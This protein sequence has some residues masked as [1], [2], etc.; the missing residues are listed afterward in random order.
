MSYLFEQP[1]LVDA[2][3]TESLLGVRAQDLDVMLADMLGVVRPATLVERSD[4][5]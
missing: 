2:S 1:L 5:A 4:N 3:D